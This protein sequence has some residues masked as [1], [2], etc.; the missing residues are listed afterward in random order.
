MSEGDA[1]F[2]AILF[3]NSS[4]LWDALERTHELSPQAFIEQL[5][6]FVRSHTLLNDSNQLAVFGVGR[7]STTLLH[8]TQGCLPSLSTI[9]LPIAETD[10]AAALLQ[11]LQQSEAHGKQL[12][13]EDNNNNEE[14]EAPIAWSGALLRTLCLI[15]KMQATAT[16]NALSTTSTSGIGTIMNNTTANITSP[17]SN[18][19][20]L[21]LS[22]SPDDPGQYLATMNAIFA[23]QR[24][25]I[26][27]DACVLTGKDS[28]FM[29]QAS[30][31]TKG[32][33]IRPAKPGALVQ[34]LLTAFTADAASREYLRLPQASGVD[35]RASCFCHK[36]P[37]ALGYVCSVCLSIFC[38]K[39][40][41]CTT[42][43]TNFPL[44]AVATRLQTTTAATA[45]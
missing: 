16:T 40:P 42:C 28:S 44:D 3:E 37:T 38:E 20:I 31:L 22:S 29:Q 21:C 24:A 45:N 1:S 34:Y 33:Y 43:G 11:R 2:L 13:A 9:P 26:L 25:N 7:G 30:Y 32:A 19:R 41:A 18:A 4:T 5:L 12:A 10:T 15:H 35:F 27:I 17:G 14:E 8:A 23:A 36:K 6:I 39:V